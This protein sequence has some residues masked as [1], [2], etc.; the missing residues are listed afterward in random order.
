MKISLKKLFFLTVIGIFVFLNTKNVLAAPDIQMEI[1]SAGN[2]IFIKGKLINIIGPENYTI[3]VEYSGNQNKDL[4]AS[5]VPVVTSPAPGIKL[6]KDGLFSA[7]IKGLVSGI[8][9][10]KSTAKGDEPRA[11]I[12]KIVSYQHIST[13]D[14]SFSGKNTGEDTS[15]FKKD[16]V[17]L[18]K[19]IPGLSVIKKSSECVAYLEKNPSAVCDIN[20][21]ISFIF[22]TL[23]A[24]TA[25]VMVIRLMIIGY[26]YMTTD[27]PFL[28][29]SAKADFLASLSGLVLALAAWLILNT[30]NPRLVE[31]SFTVD[32]VHVSGLEPEEDSEP[33]TSFVGGSLPSG[34]IAKCPQGVID[35]KSNNQTF[36]AC[37]SISTSL[38]G[39]LD[40]SWKA[41][42]NLSG[43]GF[44]TRE[45]QIA[46]RI[47]NCKDV[48]D[49]ATCKPK[50]ATPGTSRHESGLAFDFTCKPTNSTYTEFKLINLDAES[51]YSANPE[52]KK[53]FEW[54]KTNASKYGLKN[55]SEENWH[56]STDG[57]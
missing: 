5:Y 19:G 7:E 38:Q 20:S 49:S 15:F 12:E 1:S 24:I 6:E 29:V 32:A 41:G 9:H 55:Y 14:S 44:R 40:E 51:G 47:K 4:L 50:T 35:I 34:A 17:L 27:I 26:N 11:P 21:L 25:V 56:W 3:K 45:Q 36:R 8:Y 28:K 57:L 23:V 42:I 53:C 54:L 10:I 39:L 31:D 48:N 30:I 46:L 43:G 33:I 16:Y 2:S 22:R 18:A 52:T 37:K 13:S